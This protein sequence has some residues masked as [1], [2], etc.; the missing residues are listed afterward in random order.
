MA[1]NL[2]EITNNFLFNVG[3]G[4]YNKD[5]VRYYKFAKALSA[6]A[7]ARDVWTRT[8]NLTY[9]TEPEQY[10]IV[11]NNVAD[12]GVD[13]GIE[14]IDATGGFIREKITLNGTTP[15]A[16]TGLW[17]RVFRLRLENGQSN[18]GELFVSINPTDIAPANAEI[19]AHGTAGTADLGG[20]S[21]MS[22]F[23]VPTG[24]VGMITRYTPNA[25]GNADIEFTAYARKDQGV[26]IPSDLISLTGNSEERNFEYL[27]FPEGYDFKVMVLSSSGV[28]RDIPLTYD[29]I[30]VKKEWFKAENTLPR[31]TFIGFE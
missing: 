9:S 25:P 27:A 2:E 20:S 29:V 19:R 8:H 3:L 17:T 16:L 14:G 11:S 7:V 21:F 28:N 10:Y 24:Y 1:Y 30:L 31:G 18:L 4:R 22:H 23:T 6:G 12:V 15:I 13:V 26:F 5:I